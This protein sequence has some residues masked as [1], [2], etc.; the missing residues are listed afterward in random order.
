[1]IIKQSGEAVSMTSRLVEN[2]TALLRIKPIETEFLTQSRQKRAIILLDYRSFMI[3]T[4]TFPS[5]GV[6]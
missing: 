2:S 4:G 3:S 1:M 6:L 5:T